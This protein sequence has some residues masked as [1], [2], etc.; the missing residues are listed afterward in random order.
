MGDAVVAEALEGARDL[1]SGAAVLG[2][3]VALDDQAHPE[4]RDE[5]VDSQ[6]GDDGAVGGADESGYEQ[7]GGDA[8][9]DVRDLS[10]HG[11]GRYQAGQGGGVADRQV[12][13]AAQDHQGH[14]DG[15]EAGEAGAGE[16]VAEVGRAEQVAA[17]GG[18]RD[19][20]DGDDADQGEVDQGGGVEAA[21]AH[22]GLRPVA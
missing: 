20:S 11:G 18:D 8:E 12:Q 4:G 16:H 17:V 3:E 7:D 2:V 10:V 13:G 21:G 9:W 6:V 22:R 5:G 14:A 19:G 15:E 1:S